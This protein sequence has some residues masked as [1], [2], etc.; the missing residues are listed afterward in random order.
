MKGENFKNEKQVVLSFPPENTGEG[1]KPNTVVEKVNEISVVKNVKEK[2]FLD[3][4]KELTH[5][6]EN[7]KLTQNILKF[8]N[9]P[10]LEKILKIKI[11][12]GSI[13][14]YSRFVDRLNTT[15]GITVLMLDKETKENLLT[16]IAKVKSD[17]LGY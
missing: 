11:D 10:I 17:E 12:E 1:N 4:Y 6:E 5:D 14:E 13:S 3:L 2:S 16:E 9:F 7:L 15:I 8:D